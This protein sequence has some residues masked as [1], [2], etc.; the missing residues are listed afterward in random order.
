ML[1]NQNILLKY[2][3]F[4][5]YTTNCHK[6]FGNNETKK[7]VVIKKLFTL[8]V[9]ENIS[10]KNTTNIWNKDCSLLYRSKTNLEFKRYVCTK[11]ISKKCQFLPQN[12]ST[13]L[14]TTFD[15]DFIIL[16]LE[17]I[18]YIVING[19]QNQQSSLGSFLS[20][21]SCS[22]VVCLKLSLSQKK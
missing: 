8:T 5:L 20:Y 21:F 6:I 10:L 11:Q 16:I 18:V 3:V 12:N 19:F 17:I 2:F 9:R 13:P 22:Y 7:N 14:R 4:I 1:I 15:R